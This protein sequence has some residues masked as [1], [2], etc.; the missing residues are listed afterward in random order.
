M[1]TKKKESS[2]V[3]DVSANRL[4]SLKEAEARLHVRRAFLFRLIKS[5]LL[6]SVSMG[7]RKK[8][9]VF[10]INDFIKKYETEDLLED[11]KRHELDLKEDLSSLELGGQVV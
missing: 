7:S 11:L 8:V 3:Q 6:P 9:S 2:I 1:S 10:A 4:M 5:G